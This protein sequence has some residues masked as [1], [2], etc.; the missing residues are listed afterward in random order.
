[1]KFKI[2]I[3]VAIV[4]I[5]SSYFVFAYLK[6]RELEKENKIIAACEKINSFF[7]NKGP[8]DQI[9]IDD[10]GMNNYRPIEQ[11]P[12]NDLTSEELEIIEKLFNNH[13][14]RGISGSKEYG[15]VYLV[16]ENRK[17]MSLVTVQTT[18][19]VYYEGPFKKCGFQD[20]LEFKNYEA[21][22]TSKKNWYKVIYEENIFHSNNQIKTHL[23][24]YKSK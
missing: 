8:N 21:F 7:K 3:T 14:I 11:Y 2:W 12:Y 10:F 23:E 19:Y 15:F 24:S 17:K 4:C 20:W 18:C 16:S 5:L 13:H 1:M 22:L 6:N 9:N